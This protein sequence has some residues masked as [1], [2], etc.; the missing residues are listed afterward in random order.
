MYI[1]CIVEECRSRHEQLQSERESLAQ[2]LH[3]TTEAHASENS[4]STERVSAL[5]KQTAQQASEREGL[6]RGLQEVQAK[7]SEALTQSTETF[8]CI[9]L[10]H[11]SA[12]TCKIDLLLNTVI[13][14][15]HDFISSGAL[16]VTGGAIANRAR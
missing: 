16:P 5:E 14:E 10:G 3:A 4:A 7:L 13:H 8:Y 15:C 11:Y 9:R 6:E 2:Q 1:I 12:T